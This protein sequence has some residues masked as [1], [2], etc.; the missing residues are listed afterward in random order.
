MFRNAAG[1]A[2]DHGFAEHHGFQ[3][4]QTEG[5]VARRSDKDVALREILFELLVGDFAGEDNAI[6]KRCMAMALAKVSAERRTVGKR[7]IFAN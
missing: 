5:F 1:V 6:A 3:E 2:R 4:N 7:A